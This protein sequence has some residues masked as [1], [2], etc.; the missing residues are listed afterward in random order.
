MFNLILR[1]R[2]SLTLTQFACLSSC[3]QN[4]H[5]TQTRLQ[6]MVKQ[7]V[8]TTVRGSKEWRFV[9]KEIR[10]KIMPVHPSFQSYSLEPDINSATSAPILPIHSAGPGPR[11]ADNS[12]LQGTHGQTYVEIYQIL[13]TFKMMG[14]V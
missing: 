7:T 2:P 14:Y 5:N 9:L 8:K 6:V 10:D 13:K 3:T 12:A 1:H 4:A 11:R